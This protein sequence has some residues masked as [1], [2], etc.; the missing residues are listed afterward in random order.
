MRDV[1]ERE[2]EKCFG[3]SWSQGEDSL[4]RLCSFI[5]S[6]GRNHLHPQ[7]PLQELRKNR[8]IVVIDEF[9]KLAN[10]EARM[11]ELKSYIEN[12]SN[13]E[14]LYWMISIRM[15]HYEK[16]C[17]DMALIDFWKNYGFNRHY[18]GDHSKSR[19]GIQT[20]DP[21]ISG[22]LHLDEMN[23]QAELGSI[24]L[25]RGFSTMRNQSCRDCIQV[26]DLK[27]RHFEVPLIV[28]IFLDTLDY[29]N[30]DM[31]STDN[32]VEFVD[33]FWEKIVYLS[34]SM[35][36]DVSLVADGLGA[37]PIAEVI[38]R[39]VDLIVSSGLAVQGESR[40]FLEF[41]KSLRVAAED[42]GLFFLNDSRLI[43]CFVIN[44][45]DTNLLIGNRDFAVGGLISGPIEVKSRFFWDNRI[46]RAAYG[47]LC[48]SADRMEVSNSLD[49]VKNANLEA[50]GQSA[51]SE[52]VNEFLVLFSETGIGS[53][54]PPL[55]SKILELLCRALLKS[56]DSSACAVWFAG[57]KGS[58][59]L[60]ST[61]MEVAKTQP[62]S[63]GRRQIFAF[64]NFVGDANIGATSQRIELL[65][66][67]YANI[68]NLNF[69]DYFLFIVKKLL[70]DV[71]NVD[72]L[73]ACMGVLSHCEATNRAE[74]TAEVVIERLFELCN[75]DVS[76][77][78]DYL[79]ERYITPSAR[80]AER[81]R[82][83]KKRRKWQ[84]FFYREWVLF[85]F[86]RKAISI[87][88]KASK[89]DQYLVDA[90]E[91]FVHKCWY[92]PR[93]VG[94]NG[95][96]SSEMER[97]L[98]MALGSRFRVTRV[99]YFVD[100]VKS[101][102]ASKLYSDKKNSI[103]I[104]KHTVFTEGRDDVRVDSILYPT[105]KTLLMDERFEREAIRNARFLSVNL[106]ELG[107]DE[108]S[109]LKYINDLAKAETS[110]RMPVR[111]YRNS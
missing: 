51:L 110:L 13:N 4:Q 44:M 67:I 108:L 12:T 1:I 39:L 29:L 93:R 92:Y 64:M 52:G 50:A 73:L 56:D 34:T 70:A 102:V 111:G 77:A 25:R 57:S 109:R 33:M 58:L 90:Y 105:L 86:C 98:N 42:K 106:G 41:I 85:F 15:H 27:S 17:K 101:L 78:L 68:G 53:S 55:E 97:E 72:E 104:I 91:L 75:A 87:I 76:S 37:V 66:P 49:I 40:N 60:Q 96:I 3:K 18:E 83:A 5:N 47:F 89:R 71:N 21:S 9:E 43:S 84:R 32:Y 95:P 99:E 54:A 103:Y 38:N 36:R 19:Q 62:P 80:E 61:L 88:S 46:A 28:W 48:R 107:P 65:K 59:R 7:S 82:V 10:S 81:D 31:L 45:I 2:I 6:C 69:G 79:I 20:S 74:Q 16:L 100:F 22:W 94:V 14:Y 30:E 35:L 63:E 8:V 11:S 24:L 26:N 23:R